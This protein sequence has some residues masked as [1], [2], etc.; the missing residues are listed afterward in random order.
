VSCKRLCVLFCLFDSL[1]NLVDGFLLDSLKGFVDKKSASL[2]KNEINSQKC[3]HRYLPK[4][5]E[6]I[7]D[8]DKHCVVEHRIGILYKKRLESIVQLLAERC[9]V[10]EVVFEAKEA[11]AACQIELAGMPAVTIPDGLKEKIEGSHNF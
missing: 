11:V 9:S 8:R 4:Y 1:S 10:S 2:R 5:R 3:R 6:M 7:K